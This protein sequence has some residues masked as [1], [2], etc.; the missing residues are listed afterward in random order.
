MYS[1]E[2][3]FQAIYWDF[4]WNINIIFGWSLDFNLLQQV[5]CFVFIFSIWVFFPFFFFFLFES[6]VLDLLSH[7][8]GK[9]FSRVQAVPWSVSLGLLL[10]ESSEEMKFKNFLGITQLVKTMQIN[11]AFGNNCS[12]KSLT[13]SKP[14]KL[15]DAYSL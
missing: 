4:Q 5:A 11:R 8:E 14:K 3:N 13:V 6:H 10:H 7:A 1:L 15:K 12:L 9:P 2:C